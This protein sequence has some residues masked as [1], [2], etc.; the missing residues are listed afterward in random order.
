MT[1]NFQQWIQQKQTK[2]RGKKETNTELYQALTREGR[3]RQQGGNRKPHEV[4]NLQNKT[5]SKPK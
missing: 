3:E 4:L 2:H 1:K 5:G